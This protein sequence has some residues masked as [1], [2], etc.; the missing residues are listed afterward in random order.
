VCV[1]ESVCVCASDSLMISHRLSCSICR[2][3]SDMVPIPVAT[4]PSAEAREFEELAV[5]AGNSEKEGSR[6]LGQ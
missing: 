1:C 4:V 6:K 2:S 3:R 5:G